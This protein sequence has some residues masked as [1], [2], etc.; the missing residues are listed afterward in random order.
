MSKGF[1]MQHMPRSFAEE[2]ECI[3]TCEYV[4]VED[5]DGNKWNVKCM[6][7]RGKPRN[8]GKEWPT[9]VKEKKL[10]H[11]DVCIFELVR[12]DD[13]TFKVTIFRSE[14]ND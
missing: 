14:A 9:F 1:L 2:N 7:E 5:T 13:P 3:Q 11:G 12:S 10:N 8:F 6:K 4:K